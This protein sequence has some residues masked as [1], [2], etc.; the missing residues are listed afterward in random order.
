[1]KKYLL[2]VILS[3]AFTSCKKD[4]EVCFV[5]KD[6]AGNA[7]AETCGT[8]ADDARKNLTGT[9]NGVTYT[10]GSYPDSSFKKNCSQ[11]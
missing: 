2:I 9:S 8:S 6:V 11:K 4:K 10:Y 1:M 5:C 7:I 3:I